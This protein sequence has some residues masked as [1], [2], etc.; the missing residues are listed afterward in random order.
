[1]VSIICRCEPYCV[2]EKLNATAPFLFLPIDPVYESI[3][4]LCFIDLEPNPKLA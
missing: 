4:K 3:K 2:I 1:M